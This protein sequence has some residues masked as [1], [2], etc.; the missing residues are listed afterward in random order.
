[1]NTLDDRLYAA[2]RRGVLLGAYT[3]RKA[4][5][6]KTDHYTAREALEKVA[7][8]IEDSIVEFEAQDQ[9]ETR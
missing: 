9:K 3:C 2:Y 4:A 1:M 8:V 7:R 5:A 6:G